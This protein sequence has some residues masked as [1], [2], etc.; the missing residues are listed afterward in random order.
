MT[1]GEIENLA[2][3]HEIK[4]ENLAAK[5]I[6]AENYSDARRLLEPLVGCDSE[7]ALTTLGWMHEAGKG[8]PFDRKVAASYYERAA[9]L[10]CLE[11][12]NSLGRVLRN[13][14]ELTKARNAFKQGAELGNLGSMSWL[15]IMMRW[16]EGGPTDDKNGMLWITAAAEK[17]HFVAKAQL[18]R[19][20][21]Q[22]SKSIF[23]HIIYHFR[24][25]LL[26]IRGVKEHISDPYSGLHY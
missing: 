26:I 22:K 5:A 9:K 15:G 8:A 6:K 7:Y 21:K 19:I 20:E 14:G 12:F 24:K 11:A 17:G 23:R 13:E 10:G 25:A 2:L 3:Q 4:I 16:G 18:L 1:N